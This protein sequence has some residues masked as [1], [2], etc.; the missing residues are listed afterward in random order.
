MTKPMEFDEDAGK[1]DEY[2]F[3]CMVKGC[4]KEAEVDIT[5]NAFEISKCY[6]LRI[7]M[8]HYLEIKKLYTKAGTLRRRPAHGRN[9]NAD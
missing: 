7:C 8:G 5:R 1:T 2:H 6:P 3:R 9:K 4:E